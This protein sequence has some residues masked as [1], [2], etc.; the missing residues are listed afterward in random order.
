M[1]FLTDHKNHLLKIALYKNVQKTMAPVPPAE[2]GGT[3]SR[4]LTC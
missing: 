4:W 3:G 1:Q 2:A